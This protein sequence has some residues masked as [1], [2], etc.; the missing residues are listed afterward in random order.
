[1]RSPPSRHSSSATL[2]IN[3]P[4]S[5]V[6]AGSRAITIEGY[7]PRTDEDMTVPLQHRRAATTSGRCGSR[8]SPAANSRGPTTPNAPPAVIVNETLAR[9]MWQT[10]DNAI[11][12]RLSSGT[13]E[14]RSIDRRRA[15]PQILA[16]VG[17]AAALRLLSAAAEL[18]ARLSSFTRASVGDPASALRRVRDHV[19]TLDPAIP[20][21]LSMTLIGTDARRVVGLRARGRRIDDVRRDDDRARGDRHLRPGRLYRAAEHAGDRHPHG[22]RRRPDGC[23]V[24]LPAA[25]GGAGGHR[26]GDRPGPGRGGERRDSLAALRRRRARC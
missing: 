10:P 18:H 16:S 5:L 6:D 21:M 4:L 26:R 17:S 19:Q 15:R 13:G 24:G 2:A 14:W 20:I 22:D 25:R 23:G 8:C 7:A 12:K 1:M 3:V 9:R 11:G